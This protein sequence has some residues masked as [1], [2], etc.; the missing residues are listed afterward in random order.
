MKQKLLL[1]NYIIDVASILVAIISIP[2]I[3]ALFYKK[4]KYLFS[5]QAFLYNF[6]EL[7]ITR[8]KYTNLHI[9]FGV[10]LILAILILILLNF[11]YYIFMR[12]YEIKGKSKPFYSLEYSLPGRAKLKFI[13]I[14]RLVIANSILEELFFRGFIFTAV[15][16]VFNNL[17]VAILI[18]SLA[19]SLTHYRQGYSG[20]ITALF[21]GMILAIALV[22]RNNL[23][24]CIFIHAS[25]NFITLVIL[26]ALNYSINR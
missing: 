1:K 9:E 7:F 15:T 23:L 13:S 10:G 25:L 5:E 20:V 17:P 19:F 3:N 11:V 18:S 16:L 24:I 14:A 12:K 4:I 26:P 2:L 8:L 21:I 22:L 6:F